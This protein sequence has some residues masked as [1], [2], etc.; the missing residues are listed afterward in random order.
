M[1]A[2]CRR[3]MSRTFASVAGRFDGSETVSIAGGKTTRRV[4]GRFYS[5]RVRGRA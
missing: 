1:K 2:E 3:K 4:R 5:S